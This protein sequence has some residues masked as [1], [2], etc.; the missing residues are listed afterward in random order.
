[1]VVR[2]DRGGVAILRLAHG[3]ANALDPE[4]LRALA[5]ALATAAAADAVVLTGTGGMFS[6]GVDLKRLAAGGPDYPGALIPALADC[7]GRLFFHPRPL[8]AAVNGHAIAGGCVIACA[9][10]RR[11]AARGDGRFGVTE[12]LVG[13]PFPALALE[14]MRGVVPPHLFAE[15]VYGGRTWSLEEAAGHGLLDAVVE[16]H[17]LLDA[18]VREAERLAAIPAETFA[19][20][21]AQAR[22]PIRDFLALHAARIDREVQRCWSTAEAQAAIQR[23]VQQTLTR[24]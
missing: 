5:E 22:Q 19:L 13:V 24:R 2:E 4:V 20:T 17:A 21:K 6:A 3:R 15:A 14:I 10:D 11:L 1:M 12:L 9:A 8:V 18:A 7:F 16:A 23:Y